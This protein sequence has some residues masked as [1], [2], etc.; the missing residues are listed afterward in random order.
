[1]GENGALPP[2]MAPSTA[3]AF[4]FFGLCLLFSL[5]RNTALIHQAM[6]MFVIIIGWLGL[7]RFVFGGEA[8]IP[9]VNVA[10]H[11]SIVSS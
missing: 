4:C 11:A 1:M 7:S 10:A 8:L 6:A 3:V 5:F 2:R 9:F